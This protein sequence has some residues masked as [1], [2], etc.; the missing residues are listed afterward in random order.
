MSASQ[1]VAWP[2]VIINMHV[3]ASWVHRAGFDKHGYDVK[4]LDKT[5]HD[6]DGFNAAGIDR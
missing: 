1:L 3:C 2:M 4:G 5:G 6:K